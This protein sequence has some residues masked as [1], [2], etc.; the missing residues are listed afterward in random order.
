ML[1]TIS[2]DCF[3]SISI[4]VVSSTLFY[5]VLDWD[6]QVYNTNNVKDN[7]SCFE[8]L[9][10]EILNEFCV[11]FPSELPH[12]LPPKSNVDN[13][14]DIL[15]RVAPISIPLH[16]LSPSHVYEI[17]KQLMEYLRMGHIHCWESNST[18]PSVGTHLRNRNIQVC[19]HPILC[20]NN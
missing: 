19:E 1:K 17:T 10:N 11:V 12:G 20:N 7:L 13:H 9:L 15:C 18:F 3:L 2:F 14:I 16:W 8:Q 4:Q 6:I 5:S